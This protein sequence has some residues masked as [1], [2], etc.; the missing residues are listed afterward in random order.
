[1]LAAAAI[2]LLADP[3]LLTAARA[4]FQKRTETGYTCPTPADAVPVVPD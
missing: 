1:V 2:D 4:E 3:S